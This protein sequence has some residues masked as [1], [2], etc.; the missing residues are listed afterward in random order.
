MISIKED[1]IKKMKTCPSFTE[2]TRLNTEVD[3]PKRKCILIISKTLHDKWHKANLLEGRR[4]NLV[5]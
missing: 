2:A 3:S 5:W 1:K 4:G